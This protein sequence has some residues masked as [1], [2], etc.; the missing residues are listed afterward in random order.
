ME[1]QQVFTDAE[2]KKDIASA[3]KNPPSPSRKFYRSKAAIE[4]AVVLSGVAIMIF[5]RDI[6]LWLLL[7]F[8]IYVIVPLTLKPILRAHK[9]KKVSENDYTVSNETVSGVSEDHFIVRYAR[10]TKA[11]R[12]REIHNYS[13]YF[14][15]GKCWRIPN[16]N[17]SWSLEN[18]MSNAT[19]LKNAHCG[20]IMTVVT[21]KRTGK[22]V[23]AYNTRFF[24]YKN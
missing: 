9:A 21:E 19:I 23:M 16:D 3:I 15:N 12:K 22:I 18:P 11:S 14:E 8:A 13:I 10:T 6:V 4:L 2:I 24:D 17:Y 1:K 20:D 5:Y 7:A